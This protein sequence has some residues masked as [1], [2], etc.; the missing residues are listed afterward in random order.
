MPTINKEVNVAPLQQILALK[1]QVTL[2]EVYELIGVLSKP[3]TS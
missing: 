2:R 3:N 1:V